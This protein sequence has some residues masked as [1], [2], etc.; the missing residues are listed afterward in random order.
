MGDGAGWAEV[1]LG[2]DGFRILEVTETEVELVVRVE[3]TVDFVGC[4][5][6]GVRAESQ[7]RVDVYPGSGVFRAGGPAGVG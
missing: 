7:D 2:L 4:S 3:T 5:A 1:L 6:C